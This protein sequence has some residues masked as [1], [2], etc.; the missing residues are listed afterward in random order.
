MRINISSN[1]IVAIYESSWVVFVPVN[2]LH[3]S[4]QVW[5]IVEYFG[6]FSS[7]ARQKE[8]LQT[9][10]NKQRN[11]LLCWLYKI[12]NQYVKYIIE[13]SI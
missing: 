4:N 9:F 3:L 1:I 8:N 10:D 2:D 7:F 5:I 12:C 6:A 11:I 13:N